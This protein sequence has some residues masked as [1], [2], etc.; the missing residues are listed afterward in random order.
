MV[1][2]C[3]IYTPEIDPFPMLKVWEKGSI[4][5]VLQ[6]ESKVLTSFY[7]VEYSQWHSVSAGIF[8]ETNFKYQ[9]DHDNELGGGGHFRTIRGLFNHFMFTKGHFQ[10][11]NGPLMLSS[12]RHFKF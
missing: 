7:M 6:A 3:L 12:M 10:C 4:S 11:G 2:Q 1:Y 8:L 9:H 5:G